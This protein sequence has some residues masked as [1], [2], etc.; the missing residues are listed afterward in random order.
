MKSCVKCWCGHLP[1]CLSLLFWGPCP[2]PGAAFLPRYGQRNPPS[3]DLKG[4][5]LTSV[6]PELSFPICSCKTSTALCPAAP[7]PRALGLVSG[8]PAANPTSPLLQP[9]KWR[10]PPRGGTCAAPW[11]GDPQ[12]VG[13]A[14]SHWAAPFCHA[15]HP[16]G[17]PWETFG[18][19]ASPDCTR[20]PGFLQPGPARA[21]PPE[22]YV[23]FRKEVGDHGQAL[24]A[25]LGPATCSSGPTSRD[26]TACIPRTGGGSAVLNS[27][28]PRL[29]GASLCLFLPSWALV[30]LEPPWGPLGSWT[31][32]SLELGGGHGVGEGELP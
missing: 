14:H 28:P 5:L 18:G 7:L 31:R 8:G 27:E 13:E 20:A 24:D 11:P 10:P 4:L 12:G 16:H 19:A 21:C 9:L 17:L 2:C 15:A 22:K 6:P 25:R 29:E 1:R 32:L 26:T 23:A 30:G 3:Q